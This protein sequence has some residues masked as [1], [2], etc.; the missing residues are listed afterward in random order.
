MTESVPSR[1]PVSTTQTK[2]PFI[3]DEDVIYL[4]KLQAK[5][6]ILSCC[7]GI[8]RRNREFKKNICLIENVL[9]VVLT[10]S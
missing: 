10:R 3:F 2:L 6:Q 7:P 1:V 4:T 8:L 5:L 9:W